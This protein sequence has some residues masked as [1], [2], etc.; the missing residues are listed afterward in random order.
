MIPLAQL[1]TRRHELTTD[2]PLILFCHSGVRSAYATELLR[3]AGFENVL[4]LEGGIDAWSRE[5]DPGIPRY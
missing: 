4:N 5:I 1:E 3:T 2:K